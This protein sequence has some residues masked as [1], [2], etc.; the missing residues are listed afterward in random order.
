MSPED[1]E[2]AALREKLPP[3]DI[4]LVEGHKLSPLPKLQ[5]WREAVGKPFI[6]PDGTQFAVVTDDEPDTDLPRLGLDDAEGCAAL[7]CRI[8]L[9]GKEH[10]P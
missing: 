2:L 10:T 8:F 5:V 1:I 4:V 9:P 7:L 3:S 6:D